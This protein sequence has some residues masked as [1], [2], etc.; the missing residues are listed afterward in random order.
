MM[1]ILLLGSI[2]KF[3]GLLICLTTRNVDCSDIIFY[4]FPSRQNY[5]LWILV[6]HF[7]ILNVYGPYA[8]SKEFWEDIFQ[9]RL[10]KRQ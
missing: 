2:G 10:C 5:T 8:I 4:N 7:F 6:S 3:G 9:S 1:G